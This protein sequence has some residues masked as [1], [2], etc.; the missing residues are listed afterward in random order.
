MNSLRESPIFF[1]YCLV[2]CLLLTTSAHAQYLI[3]LRYSDC[4]FFNSCSFCHELLLLNIL[5]TVLM[6]SNF[7]TSSYYIANDNDRE[8]SLITTMIAMTM[9]RMN[10]VLK[11]TILEQI[12]KQRIMIHYKVHIIPQ[13]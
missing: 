7:L 2:L 11:E 3:I 1:L 6:I 10:N 8:I 9:M 12:E 13:Q 4:Y 5:L